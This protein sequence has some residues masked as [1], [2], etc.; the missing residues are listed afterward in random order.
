[1]F[2]SDHV[3]PDDVAYLGAG[4]LSTRHTGKLTLGAGS[5][6]RDVAITRTAN[7]ANELIGLQGSSSGESYTN[8]VNISVTQSGSGDAT[9]MKAGAGTL[10][11]R[12]NY[13]RATVAGAGTATALYGGD[14]DAWILQCELF[15]YG[16]GEGEGYGIVEA[17]GSIYMDS[18]W[19]YG[20]TFPAA[21]FG[22]EVLLQQYSTDGYGKTLNLN[23]GSAPENWQDVAYDDSAW[24]SAIAY[25]HPWDPAATGAQWVAY[26]ESASVIGTWLFR[27]K[28]NLD[29]QTI[30]DAYL[31]V[32]TDNYC[33]GVWINGVEVWAGADVEKANYHDYIEETNFVDGDNVIAIEVY[34]YASITALSYKLTLN[35]TSNESATVTIILNGVRTDTSDLVGEPSWGDRSARDVENYGLRH[36]SDWNAGDSHHEIVTLAVES[37]PALSLDGQELSLDLSEVELGDLADVDLTTF[38]PEDGDVLIYDEY[39]GV[40][41][42]GAG[43]GSGIDND[44]IHDNVAGEINAI[45]EKNT[46]VDDDMLIIE[47]SEDSYNK[48]KI[49]LSS[50]IVTIGTGFLIASTAPGGI[51]EL[52][53]SLVDSGIAVP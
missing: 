40:W 24:G 13:I 7:D 35:Y 30:T 36:S 3:V 43:G 28:F 21:K 8:T 41:Y 51:M 46:P 52:S 9:G 16:N 12:S 18:G 27:Y 33:R 22:G 6:L 50:L 15:G 5:Y 17:A 10:K 25:S 31:D 44:A 19:L 47:D 53:Y 48:K 1:M 4:T 39:E 34:N 45:N 2:A 20:S 11:I 26:I 32:A 37:D 14:G 42:P 29:L 49:R 38:P 23:G